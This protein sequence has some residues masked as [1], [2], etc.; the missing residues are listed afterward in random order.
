MPGLVIKLDVDHKIPVVVTDHQGNAPKIVPVKDAHSPI[1]TLVGQSIVAVQTATIVW[2][3]SS[4]DRV[5]Y[6]IGGNW[7]CFG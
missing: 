3:K 5:C 2:T 4:P 6:L 1:Q 7:H